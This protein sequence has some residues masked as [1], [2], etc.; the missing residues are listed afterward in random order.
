[1]KNNG[2]HQTIN[3]EL[4]DDAPVWGA[5]AIGRVIGRDRWQTYH[6][7]KVGAIEC[8]RKKGALWTAIP[9]ALRREFGAP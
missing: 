4:S 1:M 6:L 3:G 8:A 2:N 9:S 5:D 7:L